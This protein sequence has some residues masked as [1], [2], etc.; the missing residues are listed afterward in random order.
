MFCGL[1]T[2]QVILKLYMNESLFAFNQDQLGNILIFRLLN[3]HKPGN[4]V[5]NDVFKPSCFVDDLTV[6][7]PKRSKHLLPGIFLNSQCS[8][9]V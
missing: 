2:G 8:D 7:V 1:L 9:I 4:P 3:I 5:L 6:H